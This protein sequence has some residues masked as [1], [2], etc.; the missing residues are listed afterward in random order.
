M[1]RKSSRCRCLTVAALLSVF[2]LASLPAEARPVHRQA[3][4]VAALSENAVAW[5]RSL[6]GRLWL[7]GTAKE[8]MSID[9]N[10]AKSPEGVTIDPNGGLNDEGMSIDPD[11]RS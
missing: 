10:G 6:L 9:P 4:K 2:V 8:G 5:V 1:S 11:G 3:S 7:P